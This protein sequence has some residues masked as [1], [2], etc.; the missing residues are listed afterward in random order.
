MNI[1]ILD[2]DMIAVKAITSVIDKEKHNISNILPAYSVM[3]AKK[4]LS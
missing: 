4:T 2:D 3:Q 1:L